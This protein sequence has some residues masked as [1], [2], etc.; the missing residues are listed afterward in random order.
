M[1]PYAIAANALE[2]IINLEFADE[3]TVAVHD[4]LHAALGQKKR[5]CGISPMRETPNPRNRVAQETWLEVRYYDIWR[6]EITP[7]TRIDPRIVTDKAERL[8]AA[9]NNAT[10][11]ASGE[12]WFLNVENCEYPDD[13]TGNKSRFH[14]TIRAWGNN[15]ALVETTA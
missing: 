8:R 6:K 7:T 5:E 12:M 11:N 15:A 3:G 1:G 9:I 4:H 2:Q 10:I 13:P 14:M